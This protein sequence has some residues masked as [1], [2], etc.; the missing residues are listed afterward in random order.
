MKSRAKYKREHRLKTLEKTRETEKK[1]RTLNAERLSEYQKT[2]RRANPASHILARTKH[3]AKKEG[4]DF[5]ISHEDLNIPEFCPVFGTKLEVCAGKNGGPSPNSYS[6][7]RIDPSVG[8]M[9][10]NVRVIS[11]LAN[12]MKQNATKEQ[13]ERFARWILETK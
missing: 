12:A 7:D 5:N 4:I 3:R 13:L 9:K 6:I 8:Y 1:Y 10:G 2:W 11:N